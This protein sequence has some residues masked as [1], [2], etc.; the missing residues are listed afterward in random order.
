MNSAAM[1]LPQNA[2][3]LVRDPV[4]GNIVRNPHC[5]ESNFIVKISCKRNHGHGGHDLSLHFN[6]LLQESYKASFPLLLY[7]LKTLKR[8]SHYPRIIG[9]SVNKSNHRK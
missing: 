6:I 4:S 3:I 7:V 2:L 5:R 1:E 8:P 9:T